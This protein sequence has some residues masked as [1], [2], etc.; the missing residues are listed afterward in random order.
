MDEGKTDEHE[1]TCTHSRPLV[2]YSHR[3]VSRSRFYVASP[4]WAQEKYYPFV[5]RSP[6]RSTSFSWATSSSVCPGSASTST[7]LPSSSMKVMCTF[8]L[9]DA[10]GTRAADANSKICSH[11]EKLAG[12][13]GSKRVCNG[14][15]RQSKLPET[16]Q[17]TC[18]PTASTSSQHH[19][20]PHALRTGCNVIPGRYYERNPENVN[21]Q[22]PYSLYSSS[23]PVDV[24][25]TPEEQMPLNDADVN[26]V[27]LGKTLSTGCFRGRSR[28]HPLPT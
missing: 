24:I 3:K 14:Y 5:V 7:T 27:D 1:R 21:D 10:A 11:R 23:A 16:E 19:I 18:M 9:R 8:S 20:V 26:R 25:H 28:R 6:S 12:I 15:A 13:N 22:E 4:L 2:V 17:L